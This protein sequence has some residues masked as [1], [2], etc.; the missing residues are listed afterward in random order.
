M[1]QQSLLP[2]FEPPPSLTDRLFFAVVPDAHAQQ[3]IA[4][5]VAQLRA[6]YDL[7]SRA[8]LADRLHATLCVLGDYPGLPAGVLASA[9]KAAQATAQSVAPFSASFDQALTFMT[10]SRTSGRRPL[11]LTGGDGV[12]GLHGL[13]SALSRAL[14]KA[15]LPGNPPGFTPHITLMYDECVVP[16]QCVA[17]VSWPVQELVLLHSRIGQSLPYAV[18]GRW[19]LL[20]SRA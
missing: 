7:Q 12:A 19:P 3:S 13:Y 2:G 11:V 10:R 8:V 20:I 6:S 18:L 15:G 1:S 4:A 16:E 9:E 14:L 5:L 17:P